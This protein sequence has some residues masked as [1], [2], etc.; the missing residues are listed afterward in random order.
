MTPDEFARKV[1]DAV[2]EICDRENENAVAALLAD[3]GV[4]G[5]PFD[6]CN[7]PVA[8]FIRL[9]IDPDGSAGDMLNLTVSGSS[10]IAMDYR[11]GFEDDGLNP[12]LH[13]YVGFTSSVES[14]IIAFDRYGLY[15]ELL[16]ATS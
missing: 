13:A 3:E 8:R 7:C 11:Q 4:K 16:E 1:L 9:R 15:P 6:V 2:R 10:V 14:F 12:K 5:I